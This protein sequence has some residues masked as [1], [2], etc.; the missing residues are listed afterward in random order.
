MDIIHFLEVLKPAENV[1]TVK[2][3]SNKETFEAIGDFIIA[4]AP[5]IIAGLAMWYSYLQFKANLKTQTEQFQVGVRQQISALK[6]STQLATEVELQK[7]N[8]KGVREA[9]VQLLNHATEAYTAKIQ[10]RRKLKWYKKLKDNIPDS[11]YEEKLYEIRKP[12][13]DSL[14]RF[15]D[16]EMLMQ[17]YLDDSEDDAFRVSITTLDLCI[18]DFNSTGADNKAAKKLC[19]DLCKSYLKRQQEK[20][21]NLSNSLN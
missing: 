18:R 11:D 8:C 3:D 4:I 13:H 7:E 6:I 19:L 2:I 15:R 17:T 21:K 20:I 14:K 1:I 5:T 10:F 12:Y 9:I 16:T